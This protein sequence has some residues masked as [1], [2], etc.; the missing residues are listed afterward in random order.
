MWRIQYSEFRVQSADFIPAGAQLAGQLP[1]RAATVQLYPPISAPDTDNR[2][3]SIC[4][5]EHQCE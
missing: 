3:R 4:E 1:Y 2:L 5:R